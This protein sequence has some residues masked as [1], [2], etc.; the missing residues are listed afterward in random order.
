MA[1]NIVEGRTFRSK[2]VEAEKPVVVDVW[3][4][5]CGP[6]HALAPIVESVSEE[7]G[8]QADFYKLDADEHQSLVRKYNVMGLPTLL[9]FKNGE[10]VDRVIGVQTQHSINRV[11]H[12]VLEIEGPERPDRQPLIK[13]PTTTMGWLQLVGLVAILGSTIAALFR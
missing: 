8:E 4:N 9:F 13:L 1:V 11:L 3:A 12:R 7:F 2:V 10:V 6:C 5:W